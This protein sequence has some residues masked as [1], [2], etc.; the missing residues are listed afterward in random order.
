MSGPKIIDEILELGVQEFFN[1]DAYF[2]SRHPSR[3]CWFLKKCLGKLDFAQQNNLK[4]F[5]TI[6]LILMAT[7]M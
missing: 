6:F 1:V 5:V 4:N 7:G 3:N 2:Y